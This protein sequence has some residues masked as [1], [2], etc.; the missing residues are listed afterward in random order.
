M[1]AQEFVLHTRKVCLGLLKEI[2]QIEMNPSELER[3]DSF[4]QVKDENELFVD[5]YE[6]VE[7]SL[8]DEG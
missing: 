1:T 6:M 8:E 4:L 5:L 2:K 7:Q 3:I